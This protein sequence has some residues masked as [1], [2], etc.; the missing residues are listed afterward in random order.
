MNKQE[1]LECLSAGLANAGIADSEGT[2]EFYEE[3]ILDRIEDGMSEEEAVAAVGSVEDIVNQA[4][5]DKP[6]TVL[7]KDKISE[8]RN[9][10]K[11]KNLGW[12]WITLAVVGSPIWLPLSLAF[13]VIV[14][15]IYVAL[16]SIIF[17]LFVV[18]VALA[19]AAGGCL[20]MAGSVIVGTVPVATAI[21]AVGAALFIA[22]IVILLWFPI[23][24]L[25]KVMVEVVK[26]FGRAV[27][28]LFV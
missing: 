22:G 10:A 24:A 17:S 5:L 18:E 16:W 25:A 23:V 4:K 21:F 26:K 12:L 20:V 13:G 1:F 9:T 2:K 6:M 11:S 27:K 3:M 7:V 14:F 28:K 15:S 8:S 19:V